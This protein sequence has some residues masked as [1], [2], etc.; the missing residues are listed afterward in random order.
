MQLGIKFQRY[1]LECVA[2]SEYEIPKL[3]FFN[4][5][6]LRLCAFWR[7]GSFW[8]GIAGMNIFIPSCNQK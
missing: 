8:S 5:Y 7:N 4:S 6:S 3:Y 2:E 1:F